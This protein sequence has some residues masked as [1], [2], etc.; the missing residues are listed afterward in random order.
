M[1]G[2]SLSIWR[3]LFSSEGDAVGL[4]MT[5]TFALVEQALCKS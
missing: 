4:L 2:V 3:L 5:N 1:V